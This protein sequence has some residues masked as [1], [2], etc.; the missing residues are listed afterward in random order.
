MASTLAVTRASSPRG[1]GKT[2]RRTRLNMRIPT[3]LL[4]WAKSYAAVRHKTVTQIFVDH[5]AD[6]KERRN[7]RNGKAL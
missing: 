3:D 1:N 7:G 6:L 4:V 5:L 2:P